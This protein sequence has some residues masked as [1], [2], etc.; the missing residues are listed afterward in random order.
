MQT[1]RNVICNYSMCSYSH[2]STLQLH[3]IHLIEDIDW[4]R[5]AVLKLHGEEQIQSN[6]GSERWNPEGREIINANEP[7]KP[8][9]LGGVIKGYCVFGG[10]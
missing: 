3:D 2:L 9:T 5:H 1:I 4:P 6:S 7:Q 10:C 8:D